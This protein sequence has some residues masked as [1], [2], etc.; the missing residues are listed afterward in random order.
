MSSPSPSLTAQ[1]PLVPLSS[2]RKPAK[3]TIRAIS[4]ARGEQ[5]AHRLADLGL[6]PG[7]EVQV[8][9]RA[10]LGDPTVYHV[11]GYEL[12]LRSHE[13]ELVQVEAHA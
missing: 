6:E 3:A 1:P 7:R 4:T 5:I 10:P 8:G 12:S 9:R 13:A 11:T 2:L